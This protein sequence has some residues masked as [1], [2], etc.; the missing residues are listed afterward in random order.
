[1][2]DGHGHERLE[3][4]QP[5]V[6]RRA[7]GQ[8]RQR[9]DD[10]HGEGAK[11]DEVADVA[12]E[13]CGAGRLGILGALL[14]GLHAQ[15]G[16]E[17]AE[18]PLPAIGA[19]DHRRLDDEA[20]P[21][22]R[23]G[24]DPVDV[25]LFHRSPDRRREVVLIVQRRSCQQLVLAAEPARLGVGDLHARRLTEREVLGEAAR[26]EA[27]ARTGQQGEE[28]AA[29][30]VGHLAAAGEPG[31]DACPA[32]GAVQQA[33]V[34]ARRTQGHGHAVERHAAAGLDQNAPRDLYGL[35][36][37][38]RCGEEHDAPLV[39]YPGRWTCL[40]FV[41]REQARLYAAE[42]GSF[43]RLVRR[44]LGGQRG[45]RAPVGGRTGGQR[46]ATSTDQ[47]RDEV[48]LGGAHD[49]HIHQHERPAVT[50]H[51]LVPREPLARRA[52]HNDTI[53]QAGGAQGL[54]E[55]RG[56]HGHVIARPAR[57][58][59]PRGVHARGP[60]LPHRGEQ[61]AREPRRVGNGRKVAEPPF[62]ARIERHACGN[63]LHRERRRRD[64]AR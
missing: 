39:R 51:G 48:A 34:R 16:F 7:V 50:E 44:G 10:G 47:R 26:G 36:S 52:I 63:G 32:K 40:A 45:E 17:A 49:G 22:A 2:A 35:P 18:A 64:G 57:A 20:L 62:L 41:A 6:P 53:R 31:E 4:L 9:A 13:A 60:Q 37:L 21:G 11:A 27:L 14:V 59:Q 28:G 56:E 23:R 3:V 24:H 25:F 61:R 5:L 29:G 12:L 33:G 8:R 30:G 58:G 43:V 46:G 54:V 42:R 19:A 15:L 38:A 1:M 55:Q